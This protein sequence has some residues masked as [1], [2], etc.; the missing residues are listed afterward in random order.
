M[1]PNSPRDSIDLQEN[2][3]AFL[4]YSEKEVSDNETYLLRRKWPVPSFFLFGHFV[5]LVFSF[6]LF[7]FRP[8]TC[9][10]KKA[11]DSELG[12]AL[13]CATSRTR[14]NYSR[15]ASVEDYIQYRNVS[16]NIS[17]LWKETPGRPISPYEGP[18]TAQ[19]EAKWLGLMDCETFHNRC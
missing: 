1:A 10:S 4:L 9:H 13:L 19:S 14:P 15:L 2:Q 17:T 6:T 12:T 3:K 7:W 8:S 18:P 11:Y 5:L 16:F